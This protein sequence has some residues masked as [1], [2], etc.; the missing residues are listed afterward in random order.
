MGQSKNSGE[1]IERLF[2][3]DRLAAARLITLV[4]NETEEHH[5]IMRQIYPRTGQALIVGI[6][7]SGGVGKSSLTNHIIKKFRDQG[8]TVGVVVV[9]PSSPFS[10][11]AFLGDRIRLQR[12]TQDDGVYIRSLAS[13]GYLGGLSRATNDVIRIME[14]MGREV[15]IVE[16]LGAGQDEIDVIHI[17]Q[18]CLLVMT[19][20]MGDDI[21]AMKAGIMEIADIIVINKADLDGTDICLRHIEAILSIGSFKEGDWVPK[22]IPTI[23]VASKAENLRGIDDL[24]DAIA[25]H[26][27]HLHVTDVFEEV[28]FERIEQELGLIFKEE[29]QKLV[30]KGLKGTGKKK[31]YIENIM[32][33]RGDPYSVVD[34]QAYPA[35]R[36]EPQHDCH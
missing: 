32:S 24:M 22:V 12:H 27:K 11:G 25:E 20:G 18:T 2:A 14:A 19:P 35:A 6:T 4:E 16:T 31:K 1:L 17:A 10:G 26:Q 21:Q 23:S 29:L 9:D 28:K 36:W 33:G 5:E 7:G 34:E 13:R 3:G 30:F 8:K 15:I